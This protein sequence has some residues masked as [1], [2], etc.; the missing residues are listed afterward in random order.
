MTYESPNSKVSRDFA[1]LSRDRGKL[2][3]Y[4]FDWNNIKYMNDIRIYNARIIK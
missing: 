1:S 4:T 2:F 3:T